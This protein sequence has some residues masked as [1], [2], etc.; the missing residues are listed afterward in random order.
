M[1]G[2]AVL[3]RKGG[4]SVRL[5]PSWEPGTPSA[6]PDG[7]LF[8]DATA[9]LYAHV[10]SGIVMNG[11]AA[12]GLFI[13]ILPAVP[14][15]LPMIWITAMLAVL[16][17]RAS[18]AWMWHKRR[19]ANDR[20]MGFPGWNA[21]RE[22]LCFAAG[23]FATA[24]LWAMIP[25]LLVPRL[26]AAE[27][28]AVAIVLSGMASGSI[29]VLGASWPLATVYCA[30]L[31]L[32]M[33]AVFI[34]Q[35]TR[36]SVVIGFLAV[37]FFVGLTTAARTAS[38]VAWGGFRLG[39]INEA[40]VAESERECA[41]TAIANVA[42]RATR[43]ELRDANSLLESRIA[44]RTADLH[45]AVDDREK[46]AEALR[47]VAATDALTGIANR[48]TLAGRLT[49]RLDAAGAT[50]GSLAVFFIDLDRFKEVNDA[51]GHL[52]GDRTLRAV[53]H[54]LRDRLPADADLARWGGD[55]FVAVAAC[56]DAQSA[57]R[58]GEALRQALAE[59]WAAGEE[60]RAIGSTI[61]VAMYPC[62]GTTQDALLRAADVAMYA[63][64]T[65]GGAGVRAFDPSL[66]A[67]LRER[68]LM[69]RALAETLTQGD[70][71]TDPHDPFGR[72]WVT[73]QP[74]VG[75]ED[76][77]CSSME[78]LLRWW[79]PEHGE[80]EPMQFIGVAERSGQIGAI[81]AWVLRRACREAAAW[82]TMSSG[83]PPPSVAVNVSVA[84]ILSGRILADVTAALEASGLAPSR[85]SI[86][87][88][89]SLMATEHGR[90]LPVLHALRAIGIRIALDDFGTG[91]SS[92]ASLRTM[93]LDVVKIDK[94]FVR[95]M[96]EDD[97]AMIGAILAVARALQLVV[98]AEGLETEAQLRRLRSLGIPLLQGFL[99]AYPLAAHDVAGWLVR[100]SSGDSTARSAP[101][102]PHVVGEVHHL[103][104][105]FVDAE[106]AGGDALPRKRDMPAEPNAV[107]H[108][109]LLRHQ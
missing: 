51:H 82:P 38:R 36:E 97:G 73:Y 72:F 100:W 77:A 49:R 63:A 93:P 15:R 20:A 48:N 10:R 39:R 62:D 27:G 103:R 50:G 87:I 67:R 92:I 101:E 90:I 99:I 76:G 7:D 69:E 8:R 58:L 28:V 104:Q 105:Q 55:E 60:L 6:N 81:G 94:S 4:Y 18:D 53:A 40:L 59:P 2:T 1:R 61:G 65:E 12:V 23:L 109:K 14:N 42:L 45:S 33:G 16:S 26:D 57:L 24:A 85:L 46:T 35:A 21:R 22:Y 68:H 107:P 11:I 9:L 75:S 89:E 52:A 102:R 66:E 79:H 25:L 95:A 91:F 3:D 13:L 64:K 84:Q 86:E 98:I 41:R 83:E 56:P 32:P 37:A 44:A 34:S 71:E 19:I 108:R 74:I 70:E 43:G 47:V 78:A 106:A 96:D 17:V 80:V 5:P 54:R 30:G 31:L 88:T 29:A